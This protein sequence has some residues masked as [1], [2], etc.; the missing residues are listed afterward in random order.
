MDLDSLLN[1]VK[2]AIFNDPSTPHKP[3]FDPSG[4][5]SQLEGIFA[6]AGA[7]GVLGSMRGHP[8]VQ[9]QGGYNVRPASEDPRGDPADQGFGNVRP[10]SEDPRG[11]PAD[12]QFGNIKPASQDPL[13]D[14]AEQQ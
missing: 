12:Q 6:S 8:P 13:G 5:I 9:N 10:A 7:T 2:T 1:Q 14:P 4:L 3:G 11:D